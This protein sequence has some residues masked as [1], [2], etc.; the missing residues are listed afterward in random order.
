MSRLAGLRRLRRRSSPRRVRGLAAGMPPGDAPRHQAH[1]RDLLQPRPSHSP[2]RSV[3][4]RGHPGALR[5]TP[6]GD[7]APRRRE[8][9]QPPLH[10]AE[11]RVHLR[12][13]QVGLPGGPGLDHGGRVEDGAGEAA[14]DTRGAGVPGG[15]A[16]ECD[17][18]HRSEGGAGLLHGERHDGGGRR[19]GRRRLHWHRAERPVLRG[20]QGKSGVDT[21][22][23]RT[24][25]T[26]G[27]VH[28]I[29]T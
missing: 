27:P 24:G 3:A 4:P 22:G 7:L 8:E 13:G 11:L 29:E 1:G 21:S 23:R 25:R 28:E 2:G 26:A 12:D 20:G 5:R 16:A 18:R 9:S 10:H 14:L 17:P 15:V 19:P 6:D